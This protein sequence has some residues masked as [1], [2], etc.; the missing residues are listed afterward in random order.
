VRPVLVI[1]QEERLE[2]LGF[3]AGRLESSG[4]PYRRL[5]TWKEDVS[6]VRAGEYGAK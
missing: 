5:Q 1:E 4:L 6:G 2:G 3:L